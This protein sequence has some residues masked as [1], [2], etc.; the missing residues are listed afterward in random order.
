MTSNILRLMFKSQEPPQ[1]YNFQ[2]PKTSFETLQNYSLKI[3][4]KATVE[5]SRKFGKMHYTRIFYEY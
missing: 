2:P 5:F 3:S 1:K 4:Y